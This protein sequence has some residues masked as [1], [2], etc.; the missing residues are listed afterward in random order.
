MSVPANATSKALHWWWRGATGVAVVAAIASAR[1]ATAIK[2]EFLF[3][4][5]PLDWRQRQVQRDGSVQ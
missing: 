1:F 3:H 5:R 4:D 2:F